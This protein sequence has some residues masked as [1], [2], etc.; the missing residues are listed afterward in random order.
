MAPATMLLRLSDEAGDDELLVVA[1][2]HG[3][4][5]IPLGRG[6]PQYTHTGF[7][8][9]TCKLI[10]EIPIININLL[11]NLI[12]QVINGCINYLFLLLPCPFLYQDY[13]QVSLITLHSHLLGKILTTLKLIFDKISC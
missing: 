10:I 13:L 9:K 12:F 2:L 11:N 8:P 7:C 4:M 3:G 1:Y 6:V 5:C